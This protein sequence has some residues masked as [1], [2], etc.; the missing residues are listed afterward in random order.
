MIPLVMDA[1]ESLDIDT[2]SDWE[3]AEGMVRA[4]KYVAA[5]HG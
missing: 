1:D 5:G 3:R 4:G 2:E